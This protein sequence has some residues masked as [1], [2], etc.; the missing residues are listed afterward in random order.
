MGPEEGL[1]ELSKIPDAAK[2][3]DYPFF[4]AAQGEFHFLAGRPDEAAKHFEKAMKLA[5]SL[6]ETNFFKRKLEA[7]RLGAAENTENNEV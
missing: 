7:C 2:L 6:S 3:K 4:P 1:A 5:R